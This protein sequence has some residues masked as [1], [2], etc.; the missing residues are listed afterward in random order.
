MYFSS[1]HPH[2]RHIGPTNTISSIYNTHLVTTNYKKI[3]KTFGYAKILRRTLHDF[4][5]HKQTLKKSY[6]AFILDAKVFRVFGIS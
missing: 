5:L 3:C 1:F 6:D 4:K 2:K